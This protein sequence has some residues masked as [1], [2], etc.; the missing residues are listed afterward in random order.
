MLR[1]NQSGK[2][3]FTITDD[4]GGQVSATKAELNGL[5]QQLIRVKSGLSSEKEDTHMVILKKV[6]TDEMVQMELSDSAY[7]LL[8]YLLNE[9]WLDSDVYFSD[10]DKTDFE[11]FI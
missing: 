4:A 6:C 9:Y 7:R 8:D 3:W 5:Y 10:I 2:D 11:R 1:L